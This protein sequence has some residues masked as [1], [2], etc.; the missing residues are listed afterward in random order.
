MSE[1]WRVSET[2]FRN[3][4]KVTVTGNQHEDGYETWKKLERNPDY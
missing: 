3:A 1:H 4:G 2:L